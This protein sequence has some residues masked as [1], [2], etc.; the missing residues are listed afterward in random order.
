MYAAHHF[1]VHGPKLTPTD[2]IVPGKPLRDHRVTLGAGH[3]GC[4][5]TRLGEL[6]K[7]RA[8]RMQVSQKT[9]LG[10]S[11]TLTELLNRDAVQVELIPE[12]KGLFLKHVEYQ[13]TSRRFRA[14]VCRRYS[15]FDVFHELLLQRFPYRM[16][17]ALPPK[18]MLKGVLAAVSEREFIEG[19]RRALRR[20]I[21]LVAQHPVLS[22]DELLKTFLTFGGSDVQHK[23]REA[24]RRSGDEFTTCKIAGQAKEYL[25]PDAQGQFASSRE[26][27][28]NILNLFHGLRD[29][30][31]RMAARSKGNATDLLMFGRELSTVGS[32]AW[33][34]P[35]LALASS[36]WGTLRH[37]LKGLSVEFAL[38]ADRAA[39]QGRREE[40]DVVE[41]LDFFLDLLRSYKDLSERPWHQQIL[42]KHTNARKQT[43]NN[44]IQPRD[45]VSVE[46]LKSRI[47]QQEDAI[48]TAE[49]RCH[50]SLLCLHQETQLVFKYLQMT[51]HILGALINSQIQGHREMSEVWND[52]HPKLSCLFGSSNGTSSTRTPAG[53][54]PTPVT[55]VPN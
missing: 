23:L 30:A 14:S 5:R 40:D 31:E 45:P 8:P 39:Q 42:Q 35:P 38:L 26:L 28:H 4:F 46:Q 34:V 6:N 16:V 25:P 27:I 11:Q 54:H 41:K 7:H 12:K 37:S 53:E 55:L 2:I 47:A 52:L 17:P 1:S 20:F 21:N 19:R 32:D 3:E 18:Q 50:F 13:I 29:R 24:F 48:L 15:D 44:M 51:A 43:V 10:A 33:P 49:L 36:N 22:E 9:L